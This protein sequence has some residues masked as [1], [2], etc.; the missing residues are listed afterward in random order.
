[1]CEERVSARVLT[2]AGWRQLQEFLILDHGEGE[3][4]SVELPGIEA[5]RATPEVREAIAAADAIV[6]GP[7]NPVISIGPILATAGV[8]EALAASSAPVVAVSPLVAGRSVKGPTEA[9][10]RAVGR[11]VDAAG[12]ASLYTGLLDGMVV[13]SGDPGP[14]PEGIPVLARQTL[15][16]DAASRRRLAE[17]TLGFA[18]DL[19]AA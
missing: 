5:A 4:E 8:R 1:M 16:G 2:A 14:A 19:A 9:F 18:R 13:D 17:A 10:L 12:V 7:S 15:M 6:I 11:P 3:I